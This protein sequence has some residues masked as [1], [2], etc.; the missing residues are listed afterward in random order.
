MTER[1]IVSGVRE[2]RIADSALHE[3]HAGTAGRGRRLFF[4]HSLD[5]LRG[6]AGRG[7][8]GDPDLKWS[9]VVV[10]LGPGG[11]QARGIEDGHD[12]IPRRWVVERTLGWIGRW[13]RTSK[14]YEY[15]PATSECVIYAIM[16]RVMLRRL[17]E[18]EA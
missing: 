14:E 15:L 9:H 5:Q 13:R 7:L 4:L 1:E 11:C 10:V 16:V 18:R 12:R 6:W 3:I 17:A 2:T 8:C